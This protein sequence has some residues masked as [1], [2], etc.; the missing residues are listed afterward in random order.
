MLIV[1]KLDGRTCGRFSREVYGD[2][3]IEG[4]WLAGGGRC[5]NVVI[6]GWQG[7]GPAS[8]P[9]QAC[10]KLQ[11]PLLWGPDSQSAMPAT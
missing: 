2:Q 6:A 9:T 7:V 8:A 3:S 11:W 4:G 5:L 1:Y 10:P